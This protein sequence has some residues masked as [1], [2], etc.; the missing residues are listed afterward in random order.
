[1]YPTDKRR[2]S[3][4]SLAELAITMAIIGILASTVIVGLQGARNN[5][6]DA[7]SKAELNGA[8]LEA[9]VYYRS[10]GRNYATMCTGSTA[11]TALVAKAVAYGPCGGSIC[12]SDCNAVADAYA[13]YTQLR[14]GGYYCVDSKKFA[15]TR[16]TA[17]GATATV[18][19]SS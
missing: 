8:S 18:C 13:I 12:A 15:G 4:T 2:E 5:A 11:V 9:E 7:A 16:T 10:N 19:P 6:R 14:T 17:L 1:M 3:G